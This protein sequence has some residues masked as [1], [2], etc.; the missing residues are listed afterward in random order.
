MQGFAESPDSGFSATP[1]HQAMGDVRENKLWAADSNA[2]SGAP[3][4]A[5]PFNGDLREEPKNLA[6]KQK[7]PIA[8]KSLQ[9]IN[10]QEAIVGDRSDKK[11][12]C[13]GKRRR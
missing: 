10:K 3:I 5:S 1:A 11:R 2:K 12:R 13:F 7:D 4:K 6:G 9:E 8:L